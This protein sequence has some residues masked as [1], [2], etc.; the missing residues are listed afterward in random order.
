[1]V[2]LGGTTLFKRR[3]RI[4]P[5]VALYGVF[6]GM[7]ITAAGGI[8]FEGVSPDPTYS[9][10]YMP[11]PRSWYQPIALGT[12]LLIGGVSFLVGK[13]RWPT[14]PRYTFLGMLLGGWI[15]YPY[16]IPGT[17]S[18]THPLGYAIVLI[19]PVLV[20][21]IVWKDAGEVLR[22]VWQDRV[23]RGFGVG[24]TLITAL[25]FASVTSYFSLL[26]P[27]WQ[28]VPYETAI[29]VQS[30]SYQLVMWPTLEASFPDVPLFITF[31]PG[32]IIVVGMLSVLIGLNAMLIAHA[33]RAEQRAGTTESTAGGV[34]V[35]GS[36]TCGCC[37]PLVAKIAALAAGP[38]IVAPLYWVFVD[39]ASPLSALFIVAS[40]IL[41]AGTLIY[42]VESA[43]RLNEVT[44]VRPAD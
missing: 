18:D 27:E 30:V 6:I 37:G 15:A 8:L 16:L 24:V 12:G 10:G 33:W 28:D 40:T 41:F 34:A 44:A 43:R 19:T 4:S 5:T 13:L 35:I 14:R 42:S 38:S 21:Y 39:T 29:S 31:S 2:V 25:F 22:A 26:P 9:A 1:M 3:N 32:M 17:A 11:F 36:C 23:V 7:A 20:G